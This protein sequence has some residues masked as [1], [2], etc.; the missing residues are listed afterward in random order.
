MRLTRTTSPQDSLPTVRQRT[1][2]VPPL[3]ETV[4]HNRLS[5]IT[6][7]IMK[8]SHR[9]FVTTAFLVS[10][11]SAEEMGQHRTAMDIQGMDSNRDGLVSKQEFIAGHV[12]MKD[13]EEQWNTMKR[14][15]NDMVDLNGLEIPDS[16]TRNAGDARNDKLRDPNGMPSDGM[17]DPAGALKDNQLDPAARRRQENLPHAGEIPDGSKGVPDAIPQP[18]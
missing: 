7:R 12:G 16:S 4:C 8:R 6:E 1:D 15:K 9:F 10:T 3:S 13:R 11:V 17:R 5:Q 2:L 14:N 18:N